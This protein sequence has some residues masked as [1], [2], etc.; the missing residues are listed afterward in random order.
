MSKLG[1][2]GSALVGIAAVLSLTSTAVYAR[3]VVIN[4]ASP[5]YL[6]GRLM[7]DLSNERYRAPSGND[8]RLE[9]DFFSWANYYDRL[10]ASLASG[11]GNTRWSCPTASG[12]APSPMAATS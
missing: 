7:Q 6:P 4:M 8:V 2:T 11:D 10:A 5:E 9:V 3:D 1:V 12:S